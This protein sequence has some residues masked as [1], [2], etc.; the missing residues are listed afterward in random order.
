MHFSYCCQ[1]IFTAHHV[2]KN[3]Q[4]NLYTKLYLHLISLQAVYCI[5][6]CSL[7]GGTNF[8]EVPELDWKYLLTYVLIYLLTLLLAY[9]CTYLLTYLFT[10]LLAYLFTYLLIYL[11]TC[12]LIYLRNYLITYLL[13]YSLAYLFT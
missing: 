13:T 8:A 3:A 10:Y 1:N 7:A 12:L 4:A 6:C 2:Q 9:L 5:L 11:L